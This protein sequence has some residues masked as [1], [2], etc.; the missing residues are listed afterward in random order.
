[1]FSRVSFLTIPAMPTFT[2]DSF[3]P[4]FKMAPKIGSSFILTR[5]VVSERYF[6]SIMFYRVGTFD[7][8]IALQTTNSS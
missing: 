5:V 3:T 6:E 4:K 7:A 1:M 8:T 2:D